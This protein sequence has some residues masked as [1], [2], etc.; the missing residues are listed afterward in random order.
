MRNRLVGWCMV[1]AH[2]EL[3][4]FKVKLKKEHKMSKKKFLMGSFSYDKSKS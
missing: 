2:S 4:P 1:E 3:R